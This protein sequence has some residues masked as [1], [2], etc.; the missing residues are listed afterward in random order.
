M[1]REK[2]N[3]PDHPKLDRKLVEQLMFGTGRVRRFTQDS[4]VLPDVWLEYAKGPGERLTGEPEEPGPFPPVKLLLTPFRE[5]YAGDIRRELRERLAAE[6][7][8]SGD[9]SGAN[10]GEI[11]RVIYNQ[12]TVAATLCF[13]DLV[14]AVL[15]MTAFWE[16]LDK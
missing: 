5:N 2:H 6:R 9:N 15:P 16:R 12:S 4:P 1:G 7:G 14:R 11:P 3:M 8:I 10:S 13:E